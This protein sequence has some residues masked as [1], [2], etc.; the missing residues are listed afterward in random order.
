MRLCCRN[1]CTEMLALSAK[2]RR[3]VE[4]A[5]LYSDWLRCEHDIQSS[6]KI[7]LQVSLR[8]SLSR[9]LLLVRALLWQCFCAIHVTFLLSPFTLPFLLETTPTYPRTTAGAPHRTR[10]LYG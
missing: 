7:Q 4:R 2:V 5:K 6:S 9:R 1:Q 3:E 8:S 10:C